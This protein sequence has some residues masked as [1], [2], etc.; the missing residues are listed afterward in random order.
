MSWFWRAESAPA[1]VS[2]DLGGGFP[3]QQSAEA[4]LTAHFA[5]LSADGVRAVALYEEERLVYGPMSLEAE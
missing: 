1:D 2:A 5:E 4:W 3:S